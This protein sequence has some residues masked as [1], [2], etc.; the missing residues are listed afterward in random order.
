MGDKFAALAPK[1]PNNVP[2]LGVLELLGE[3]PMD[4]L[5]DR[6]DRTTVSVVGEHDRV[7]KIWILI[8][9]LGVNSHEV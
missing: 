8:G 9:L 6:L 7:S 5:A 1:S 2:D 4:L 3:V